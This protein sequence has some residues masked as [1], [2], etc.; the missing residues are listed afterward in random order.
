MITPKKQFI[1]AIALI[2]LVVLFV[3]YVISQLEKIGNEVALVE[4]IP[5]QHITKFVESKE[6]KDVAT[7]KASWYDYTY[8]GVEVTKQK[9]VTASRDYP[10]GSLVKVTNKD[11]GKSVVAKVTDYGPEEAVFP[12]RIVDL[13]SKAFEQLAPLSQGT[14]NVEVESYPLAE[15]PTASYNN[16]INN[17]PMITQ[18]EIINPI[19]NKGLGREYV[20]SDE[21]VDES[22]YIVLGL[23]VKVDGQEKSDQIVN[24]I[25]NGAKYETIDGTG[26][27]TNVYIDGI[28]KTVPYYPFRYEFTKSGKVEI[29]FE[30]NGE[31][32][33]T[34]L[35]VK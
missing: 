11:N 28:K 21:I 10:R 9:L 14:I 7:G 4:S 13:G 23:V 22:N 18:L 30:C 31:M 33:W 19:P 20:A 25:V 27:I 12:E 15:K 34:Q 5:T 6:T 32:T 16:D 24:V 3:W 29:K 17:T 26:N 35:D 8:N 2:A 1:I